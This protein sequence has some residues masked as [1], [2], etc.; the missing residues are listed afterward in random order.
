MVFPTAEYCV[1]PVGCKLMLP[2]PETMFLI[3]CPLSPL[4]LFL[5]TDFCFT[6][7]C[8]KHTKEQ[9]C[10]LGG[11]AACQG[12]ALSLLL[13]PPGAPPSTRQEG[14]LWPPGSGEGLTQRVK[15]HRRVTPEHLPETLRPSGGRENALT[16]LS[17]YFKTALS[18]PSVLKAARGLWMLSF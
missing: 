4:K 5:K 14:G 16:C 6:C 1:H 18:S 12:K 7:G 15:L 9:N 10:P 17:L 11:T 13:T 3:N 2:S 8:G